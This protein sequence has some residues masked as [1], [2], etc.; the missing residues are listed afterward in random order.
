MAGAEYFSRRGWSQ[1]V[2]FRMKPA[3]NSSLELHYFGVLD[4]GRSGEPIRTRVVR[5]RA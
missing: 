1:T 2:Q 4:R 5:R 3:E